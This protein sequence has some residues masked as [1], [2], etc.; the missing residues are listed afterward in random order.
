MIDLIHGDCLEVMK[1]FADESID[2]VVTDPPYKIITGGCTV[3][4]DKNETRGIFDHRENRA[5]RKDWSD[6]CRKGKLFNENDI[7]FSEWL[8]EVYRVLKERTHFYVMV[9]DRNMQ[10]MLNEG[11]RAGFKLVNILT[12]LKS[13]CTPNRY[14]MKNTEF[15]IL[16]RKGKARTINDAGSKQCIA[17]PNIKNKLHPTQKPV[18]LMEYYIANSTNINEFVLDPFMGSGSSGVA[19]INAERKFIGIEK[20]WEYFNIAHE[21]VTNHKPNKEENFNG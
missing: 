4:P 5:K 7:K 15:T 9:N 8:P 12:W 2:C 16:F 14:Y 20:D 11:Q 19:C 18:E 6:N 21:R 17:L 13:N 1:G 10:E 3:I